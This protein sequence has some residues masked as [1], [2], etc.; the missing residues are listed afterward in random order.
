M[1]AEQQN[2]YFK[3]ARHLGFIQEQAATFASQRNMGPRTYYVAISTL[4][5]IVMARWVHLPLVAVDISDDAIN[6]ASSAMI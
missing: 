5:R 6:K 1:D 2:H 3:V 4:I